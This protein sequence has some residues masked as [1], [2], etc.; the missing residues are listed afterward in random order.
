MDLDIKPLTEP[1]PEYPPEH[2]P[3]EDGI[4]LPSPTPKPT[5]PNYNQPDKLPMGPPPSGILGKTLTQSLTEALKNTKSETHTSRPP[6]RPLPAYLEGRH[7]HQKRDIP[8]R[9]SNKRTTRY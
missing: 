4:N 6:H 1:H 8:S 7:L 3:Q 9:K 5:E 2:H